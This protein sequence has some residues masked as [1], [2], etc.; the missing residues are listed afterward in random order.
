MSAYLD[1]R[2]LT[3]GHDLIRLLETLVQRFFKRIHNHLHPLSREG[4]Q[5]LVLSQVI[6]N[7]L[8]LGMRIVQVILGTCVVRDRLTARCSDATTSS[9]TIGTWDHS[10]T[11]SSTADAG[12]TSGALGVT[13]RR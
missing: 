2:G 9:T 8:F 6:G 7:R 1:D 3:H 10:A 12:S 4:E 11:P 5:G 13:T